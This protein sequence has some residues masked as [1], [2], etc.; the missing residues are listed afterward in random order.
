MFLSI[1]TS[2][3]PAEADDERLVALVRLAQG[4][5]MRCLSSCLR[6]IILSCN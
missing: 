3:E 4:G 1:P 6:A 5:M 2:R